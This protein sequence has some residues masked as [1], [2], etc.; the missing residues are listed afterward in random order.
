MLLTKLFNDKDIL[1]LKQ[2][3]KENSYYT[4]DLFIQPKNQ[5]KVA[6]VGFG[7]NLNFVNVK[8]NGLPEL[9]II[10]DGKVISGCYETL[11]Q[12]IKLVTDGIPVNTLMAVGCFKL[13]KGVLFDKVE[14][15]I[16]EYE[17]ETLMKEMLYNDGLDKTYNKLT[18]MGVNTDKLFFL[19]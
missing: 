15:I 16:K 14:T 9:V 4:Y 13:G 1:I 8:Y 10:E 7:T 3:V 2:I 11:K 18:Q 6:R 5:Y 17:L 19:N 12:Q